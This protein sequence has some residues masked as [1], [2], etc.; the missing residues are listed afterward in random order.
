MGRP[1][2]T[3]RPEVDHP[4]RLLPAAT[5][6]HLVHRLEA[7]GHLG[8][9]L[10]VGTVRPARLQP[11][12]IRPRL[13]VARLLATGAREVTGRLVATATR[14]RLLPQTPS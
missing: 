14:P 11:E 1:A 6:L 4:V 13:R 7:T 5:D 3:G 9:L 10:Q 8:E 12:A 2:A